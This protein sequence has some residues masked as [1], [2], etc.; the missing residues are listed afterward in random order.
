[1]QRRYERADAAAARSFVAKARR[2]RADP[3]AH[4]FLGGVRRKLGADRRAM[5]YSRSGY[6]LPN[7][8][9]NLDYPIETIDSLVAIGAGRF[10]ARVTR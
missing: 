5:A 6:I 4:R 10:I 7:Y 3:A 9:N 1:V 2:N 8:G